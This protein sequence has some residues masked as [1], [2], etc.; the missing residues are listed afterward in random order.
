[1]EDR[2]AWH[3]AVHG[4]ERVRQYLATEQQLHIYIYE[5]L[6]STAI[7]NYNIVNN[8]SSIKNKFLKFIWKCTENLKKQKNW[9]KK[10]KLKLKAKEN[11]KAKPILMHSSKE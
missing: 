1:M 7:I 8:Y 9:K 5:S 11:R 3:A 2:G 6:C 10:T 4:V